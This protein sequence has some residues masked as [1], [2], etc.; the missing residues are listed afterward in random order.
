VIP[1]GQTMVVVM[2]RGHKWKLKVKRSRLQL[3]KCSFSK[4]VIRSRNKLLGCVV[5][6]SS[7]RYFKKRLYEWSTDVEI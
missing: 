1:V 4:R 6:A 7:V 2:L 3:R 5:D